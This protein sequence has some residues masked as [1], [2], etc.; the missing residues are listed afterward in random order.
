MYDGGKIITGIVIFILLMT[1]P[2]WYN[3]AGE[4]PDHTPKKEQGKC[5]ES[6]EFMR[7]WHMD[8]LNDWRDAVVR[9]RN[10]VYIN[11]KGV[12]HTMSL[13]NTCMECHTERDKFCDKC[14]DYAAVSVY[15]FDCH[16][17]NPKGTR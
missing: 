14:H 12:E 3:L 11:S 9:E 7:A 16:I 5:V 17:D 15:C 1:F 10:R 4:K 6:V 8:L 13:S 2:I